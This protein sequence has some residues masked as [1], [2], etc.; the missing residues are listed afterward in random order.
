[1]RVQ[2]RD[3]DAPAPDD[4]AVG[5]RAVGYREFLDRRIGDVDPD[6]CWYAHRLTGYEDVQV[7]VDVVGE[8]LVHLGHEA[9]GASRGPSGSAARA[10][11]GTAAAVAAVRRPAASTRSMARVYA[12]T[13]VTPQKAGIFVSFHQSKP[14]QGGTLVWALA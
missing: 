7:G 3:A 10:T 1:M 14:S 9:G 8:V 2:R 6:P 11:F 13:G 4:A 12:A 5:R